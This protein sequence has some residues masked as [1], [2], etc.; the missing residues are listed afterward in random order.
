MAEIMKQV[1]RG[2]MWFA[3]NGDVQFTKRGLDLLCSAFRTSQAHVPN[4]D[5]LVADLHAEFELLRKLGIPI[6]DED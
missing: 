3:E 5:E 1:P 6:R 4:I 2:E